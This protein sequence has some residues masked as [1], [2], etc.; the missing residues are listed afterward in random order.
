MSRIFKLPVVG[1]IFRLAKAIPIA[2]GKE[3]GA[4]KGEG[5]RAHLGRAQRR[6]LVCI[7]PEGKITY[8]G[9]L[10]VFRPGIERILK[11]DPVP[12]VPMALG[13]LWGSFFS[14]AAGRA[15]STMPKPKRRVIDIKIGAPLAPTTPATDLQSSVR[16]L[17]PQ[18]S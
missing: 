6:C 5:V 9:T 18:A 12:V 11:A 15:M 4:L 8:D 7:F 17:M 16:Q 1:L 10:D 13:G 3:D 14:R 2:P